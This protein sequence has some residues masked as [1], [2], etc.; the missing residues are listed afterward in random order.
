[1]SEDQSLTP[2]KSKAKTKSE[3]HA[4]LEADF[5]SGAE[6]Y[7][8]SI[9]D[10]GIAIYKMQAD[11]TWTT[12]RNDDGQYF[13]TWDQYIRWL[14]DDTGLSRSTLFDYKGAVN[15]ALTNGLV[16][17]EEQFVERGGVNS[18]RYMR[19]ECRT[20]YAGEILGIKG[21]DLSREAAVSVA[22]S[23]VQSM[24][25]D[26]RPMDQVKLIKEVLN[27]SDQVDI[28]FRL[29]PNLD[30][31]LDLIWVKESASGY[32]D[33]LVQY[34]VPEDVFEEL[35]QKFHILSVQENENNE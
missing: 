3:Y 8:R 20:N 19:R 27:G 29:R 1:M 6:D 4:E 35:K 28:F 7:K 16:E 30:G 18:F 24:D 9:N 5:R 25:P 21:S 33:G 10:M 23:A 2:A 12:A 31:G 11:S 17:D 32:E 34:I 26:L 22:K 15:F 13:R 14:A